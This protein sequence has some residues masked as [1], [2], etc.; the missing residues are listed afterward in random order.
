MQQDA[1]VREAA[2]HVGVGIGMDHQSASVARLQRR[3][4][5]VELDRAEIGG[6][7]FGLV[8]APRPSGLYAFR[9]GSALAGAKGFGL[10]LRFGKSSLRE[11]C[12]TR[13]IAAMR[14]CRKPAST[15]IGRRL[16]A[17]SCPCRN[18]CSRS[19]L[20]PCRCCRSAK[21]S[22]RR[23]DRNARGRQFPILPA[24]IGR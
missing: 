8:L 5:D 12:P 20:C 6:A 11:R 9:I 3:F 7:Q 18:R 4:V 21:W 13:T 1:V 17:C 2:T 24:A 14:V 10:C 19:G 16:R 23:I 15:R 22:S